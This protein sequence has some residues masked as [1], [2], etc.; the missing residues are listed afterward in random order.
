M[1]KNLIV[2]WWSKETCKV[3]QYINFSSCT[4]SQ[5]AWVENADLD[6]HTFRP[7][8]FFQSTFWANCCLPRF[9]YDTVLGDPFQMFA[10]FMQ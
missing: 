9:L 4:R 3:M 6:H 2:L 8:A 5:W 10:C 1:F 7:T